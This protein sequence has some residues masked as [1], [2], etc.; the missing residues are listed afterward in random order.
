M[1][2]KRGSAP[3]ELENVIDASSSED[4]EKGPSDPTQVGDLSA[5]KAQGMQGGTKLK[6]RVSAVDELK[7]A[8]DI[9]TVSTSL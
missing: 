9:F 7:A 6:S 3:P 8:T 1:I 4:I 5:S 2:Y